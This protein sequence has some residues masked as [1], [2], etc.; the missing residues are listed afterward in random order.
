MNMFVLCEP[1]DPWTLLLTRPVRPDDCHDD[2]AGDA[3]RNKVPR[4]DIYV[5]N[6]FS[7]NRKENNSFS[8]NDLRFVSFF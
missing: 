6:S 4:L 2:A 3:A 5:K 1:L 8:L 7:L